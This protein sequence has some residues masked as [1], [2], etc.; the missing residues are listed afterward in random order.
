MVQQ[1]SLGTTRHYMQ[2]SHD[3][4]EVRKGGHLISGGQQQYS[5]AVQRTMPVGLIE[6]LPAIDLERS[7]NVILG[8]F[9]QCSPIPVRC[10]LAPRRTR[11][12]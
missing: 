3:W 6:L 5:A 4:N 1:G 2:D 10:P 12:S 11:L 8:A 7:T 9:G